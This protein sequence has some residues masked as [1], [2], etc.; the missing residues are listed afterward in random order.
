[1]EH[2]IF[3]KIKTWIKSD[4]N[5]SIAPIAL[6]PLEKEQYELI[7]RVLELEKQL[8]SVPKDRLIPFSWEPR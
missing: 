5:R 7:Q 2:N 1:V 3:R 4:F 8:E 6:C